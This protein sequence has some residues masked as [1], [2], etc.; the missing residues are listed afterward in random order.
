MYAYQ[1]A[2]WFSFFEKP[3]FFIF[4]IEEFSRNRIGVLERILDFLGLPLYDPSGKFG[5]RSRAELTQLLSF[6]INKTPRKEIFES[7]IT[8][9]VLES[10][11]KYFSPHNKIL[12]EVL[13]F[14]PGYN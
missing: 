1:F 6:V 14:D 11:Y 9:D 12:K 10:L 2:K 8:P 7:Q 5:Y 4:T 3:Q 13:G